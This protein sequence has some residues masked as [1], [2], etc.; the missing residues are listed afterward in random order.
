MENAQQ[1]LEAVEQVLADPELYTDSA[2]KT[3]LTKTLSQQA[4][5]KARLDEAERQWLSA[6]ES[7]EA[8]E[9]ELLASEETT[10]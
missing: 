5:I 6:E 2:R 7:L 4:E 9:A 8:M 3:E 10:G 1:A